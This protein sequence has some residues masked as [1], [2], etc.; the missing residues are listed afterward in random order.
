MFLA[1]MTVIP[2]IWPNALSLT[3]GRKIVLGMV[4]FVIVFWL[5]MIA[6]PATTI[7]KYYGSTGY[8]CCTPSSI[9]RTHLP[10]NGLRPWCWI[11]TKEANGMV[12]V[13]GQYMGILTEYGWFWLASLT[14]FI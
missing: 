12:S 13:R 2:A 11:P 7:K 10:N 1:I 9:Y 14:C 6:I 5:L 8:V 3:T 4:A